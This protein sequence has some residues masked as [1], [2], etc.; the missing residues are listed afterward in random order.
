M[1]TRG[2]YSLFGANA[3]EVPQGAF[4]HDLPGAWKHLKLPI[5]AVYLDNPRT[6]FRAHV[7]HNETTKEVVIA[8]GGTH[9]TDV[10]DLSA[11]VEIYNGQLPRQF[12]DARDLYREVLLF[13]GK[14]HKQAQISFTGH[15]LG[16]ALAQY[17]A[18]E[19]QGCP[20]ATFGAPGI[21]DALGILRGKY[22]HGYSYPVVNHV[23]FGDM[24]GM[25]GRHLGITEYYALDMADFIMS[26]ALPFMMRRMIVGSL[27]TYHGHSIERY[28]RAFQHPGGSLKPTGK[29]T[30][31]NGERH[32]IFKRFNGS[33]VAKDEY[34]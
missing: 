30:Y 15:S 10:G 22:N 19:A 23:A 27:L 2:E 25:Y 7:Y 11:D 14:S 13:L 34:I 3:Y 21:L 9:M 4:K 26:S 20:A 28:R 32:D 17:M 5:D 6:G 33:G 1:P 18:I 24:F 12:Y 8:F 29:V 16:G 31:K